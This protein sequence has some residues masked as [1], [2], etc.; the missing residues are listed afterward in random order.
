MIIIIV[1]WFFSELELKFV[2]LYQKFYDNNLDEDLVI[3][4]H[5]IVML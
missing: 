4:K 1:L 5:R 2:S 3:V